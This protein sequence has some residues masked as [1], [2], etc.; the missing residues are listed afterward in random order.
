L[1]SAVAFFCD[2]GCKEKM[3]LDKLVGIRIMSETD[4]DV[5]SFERLKDWLGP[6]GT[7]SPIAQLVERAA[8]NR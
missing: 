6:I 3:H 4:L 5:D 2:I 7:V 1:S 8:V